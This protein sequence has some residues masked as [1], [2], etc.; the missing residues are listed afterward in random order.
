MKP[1]HP[2]FP[3]NADLKWLHEAIV[4]AHAACAAGNLPFGAILVDPSG[5]M[6]LRQ[7][8]TQL[9][10]CDCTG[11]AETRLVSAASRLYQ[12]EFLRGCTLYASAEPCAMCAGA[13]YWSNIGRVVFAASEQQ[14][15]ELLEGGVRTLGFDLP[16]RDVFARGCKAIEVHGPVPAVQEAAFAPLREFVALRRDP[17]GERPGPPG[18]HSDASVDEG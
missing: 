1:H 5:H 9:S 12:P 4:Q 2:T 13:I 11:H 8:N 10:Q 18:Q 7:Q 6:L 14:V 3:S 15:C 17:A 16:C